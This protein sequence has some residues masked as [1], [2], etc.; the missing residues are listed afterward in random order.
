MELGTEVMFVWFQILFLFPS[1]TL[2]CINTLPTLKFSEI[3]FSIVVLNSFHK[4]K[5]L[6]SKK[7]KVCPNLPT[8]LEYK[9]II[10]NNIS[11]NSQSQRIR[12]PRI[13]RH[14]SQTVILNL[15][16]LPPGRWIHAI[17]TNFHTWI[18]ETHQNLRIR[19]YHR[20][21]FHILQ[22]GELIP[23]NW[24]SLAKVI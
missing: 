22:I 19:R 9:I 21:A 12:L 20:D 23:V 24:S 6:W 15:C 14:W 1:V 18:R 11:K 13:N 4:I 3:Y 10:V 16:F 2:H 8:V 17:L 7:G 5:I